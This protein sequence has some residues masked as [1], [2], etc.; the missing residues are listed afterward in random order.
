M[1]N[2]SAEVED[3]SKEIR[4]R[5]WWALCFLERQLAVM[6]GR[7]PSFSDADCTCP[8]PL[9][10]DESSVV[11]NQTLRRLSSH[12]S[13]HNE[14]VISTPSPAHSYSKATSPADSESPS[15]Q[16]AG[17][18][19]SFPPS[20]G[21]YFFHLTKLSIFT[22]EVLSRLYRVVDMEKSWA[23]TQS[24][25]AD[26]AKRLEKWRQ[27]LPLAF[28]FTKRI[29][30]QQWIRQRKTLGFLYF[31]TMLIIN[32]PCLCRIDRKIPNESGKAKHFN[33]ATAAKCVHAAI[34]MLNLLPDE[35][36]PV[37]MYT[38]SPW[39]SLVHHLVEAAVVC[40]LELSFRADHM[41]HEVDEVFESADKAV[42]WLRSM[43]SSNL[44]ANRAWRM[45][46]EMLRKVSPKVGKSVSD[47]LSS[48]QQA[49]DPM[50]GLQS[51]HDQLNPFRPGVH[52]YQDLAPFQPPIFTTYDQM[53]SQDQILHNL[54]QS[55]TA[56][57]Y[58]NMYPTTSGMETMSYET[59]TYFP[60][61]DPNQ[62]QWYLD[63]G[64]GI[65]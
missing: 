47:M 17:R 30:D 64:G 65:G 24:T 37:G 19:E 26:L 63:G 52:G 34:D 41:P 3:F 11:D 42:Q 16:Q 20:I 57:N 28:D 51:S 22:N 31:S 61:Q 4:Y 59:D 56:N 53:M 36:N 21:L 46:D 18:L 6:T 15:S 58:P 10:V 55:S 32:R 13:A 39:W 44:A 50:Q 48:R 54:L 12:R 38:Q 5:T 2:D 14:S 1:R 45:C 25:M 33:Q 29:R 9:P 23:E 43:S 35:P 7:T 60:D 49:A 27:A 40:M 8:Q 62:Q